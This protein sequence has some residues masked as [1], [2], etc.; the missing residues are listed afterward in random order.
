MEHNIGDGK[1]PLALWSIPFTLLLIMLI[2]AAA[3]V[4]FQFIP[5]NISHG[6]WRW[7]F[8][9]VITS[10]CASLVAEKLSMDTRRALIS[11]V[12]AAAFSL[13]FYRSLSTIL[14]RTL[15]NS[16]LSVIPNPF[17]EMAVYTSALTIIPGALI[18]VVFGGVLGFIP[19]KSITKG[20]IEWKIF[21]EERVQENYGVEKLCGRCGEANPI[22]SSFCPFCG[23]EPVQRPAPR[24]THCRFCG[25]E[26]KYRGQ[27]CPECGREID[28]ISKPL[29]FYSL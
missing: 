25:A 2:L 3:D 20:K 11:M 14:Q 1:E 21:P 19:D 12:S 29:V 5:L 13:L 6:L 15:T 24:M 10:I 16:F 8:T 27:F 4:L 23:M 26:L 22:D 28:M 17:V 18:G 9:T 7:A